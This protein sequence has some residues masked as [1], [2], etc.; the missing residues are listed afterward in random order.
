MK[1]KYVLNNGFASSEEEDMKKLSKYAKEGWILEKV[2][3]ILFYKLKKDKPQNIVYTLDYQNDA[4]EDYFS[5]MKEAGW[6]QVYSKGDTH[7]FSANEGTK[8]IYSDTTTEIDK[9]KGAN[10]LMKKGTVMTLIIGVVLS[11]LML[12]SIK[13]SKIIFIP[14]FVIAILDMIA[15][16][17]C[18]IPYMSYRGRMEELKKYGKLKE[19]RILGY[20]WPVNM[21]AGILISVMG[22][23]DLI[24]ANYF[25]AIIALIIGMLNIILCFNK[26]KVYK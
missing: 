26:N 17:C 12:I 11:L 4:D 13:F 1:N 10:E 22:I 14:L 8:P 18:C 20:S 2:S 6:N 24:N 23:K 7:I 25:G 9:Y 16:I 15:F 21:L 19:K 3:G 5:I